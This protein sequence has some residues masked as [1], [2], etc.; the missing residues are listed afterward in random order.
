MDMLSAEPA[1][2]WFFP[3][4]FTDYSTNF[5]QQKLLERGIFDLSEESSSETFEFT[6]I[7][8]CHVGF[9]QSDFLIS[10]CLFMQLLGS[11]IFGPLQWVGGASMFDPSRS[12]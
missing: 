4:K 8:D 6:M 3:Q 11:I 5:I 10:Q 1:H 7:Y 2:L 9:I 12:M